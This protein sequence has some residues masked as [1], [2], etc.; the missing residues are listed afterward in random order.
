METMVSYVRAH[1]GN[2]R[3]VRTGVNSPKADKAA[4]ERWIS[5]VETEL[6]RLCTKLEI[7]LDLVGWS[8]DEIESISMPPK[9]YAKFLVSRAKQ[10]YH[11]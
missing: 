6:E 5:Q 4:Y 11:L 1:D 9:K 7:D 10:R 2:I 3:V 8:I